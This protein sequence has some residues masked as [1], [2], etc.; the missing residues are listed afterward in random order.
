M[1]AAAAAAAA[2]PFSSSPVTAQLPP[3]QAPVPAPPPPLSPPPP[4]QQRG[5]SGASIIDPV[6]AKMVEWHGLLERET[7]ATRNRAELER[8]I[9]AARGEAGRELLA[10]LEQGEVL[11]Q[12]QMPLLDAH[13]FQCRK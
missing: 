8:Q 2:F 9:I 4:P 10:R 3:Q 11:L 12:L 7:A 6:W 1:G 5:V 13:C